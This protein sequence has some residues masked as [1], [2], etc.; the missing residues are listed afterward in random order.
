MGAHLALL[1]RRDESIRDSVRRSLFAIDGVKC[2]GAWTLPE[3]WTHRTRPPLLGKPHRTRFP[4]APTRVIV[5]R[6]KKN[7]TKS[8]QPALHTKF[9]TLPRRCDAPRKRIS[10]PRGPSRFVS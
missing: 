6:S 1:A 10:S 7:R 9:R 4:T 5:F 8:C 3:P 2:N